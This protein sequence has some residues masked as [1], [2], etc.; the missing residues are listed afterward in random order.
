MAVILATIQKTK[1]TNIV[2][3]AGKKKKTMDAQNKKKIQNV[4]VHILTAKAKDVIVAVVQKIK[5]MVIMAVETLAKTVITV[6]KNKL[7]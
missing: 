5:A 2:A 7:R 1:D 3:V 6:G 4:D